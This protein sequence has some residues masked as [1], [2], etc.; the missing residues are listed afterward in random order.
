MIKEE[1]NLK[2]MKINRIVPTLI[3]VS[4]NRLAVPLVYVHARPTIKTILSTSPNVAKRKRKPV[5]VLLAG[6]ASDVR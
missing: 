5:S 1:I 3:A 6:T 4:R 2:R